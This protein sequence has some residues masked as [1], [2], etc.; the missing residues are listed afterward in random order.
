MSLATQRAVVYSNGVP[1]GI[2]TV[3]TGRP[4]FETPT[5]TFVILQKRVEHYSNIY[6]NA[7]MPYMQR[8]TWGGVALHAGQLPGYPASHGCIR[9][10]LEFAR[11]LYDVTHH[12]MTVVITDRPAVPR[13]PMFLVWPDSPK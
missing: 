5:G 2:S 9:L 4:G 10:P 6:D 3:S 7:P 12:G 13:A 11:L 1:I 8:P